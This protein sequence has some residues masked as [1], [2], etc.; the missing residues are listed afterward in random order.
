MEYSYLESIAFIKAQ[1]K[2][3]DFDIDAVLEKNTMSPTL[4]NVKILES[5]RG[6]GRLTA[7]YPKGIF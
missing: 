7:L 1:I 2:K 3:I 6:V 4:K 5:I